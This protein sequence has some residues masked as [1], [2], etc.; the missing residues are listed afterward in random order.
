M[1]TRAGVWESW[2]DWIG[3]TGMWREPHGAQT[4]EELGVTR[5][6]IKAKRRGEGEFLD[7]EAHGKHP[8]ELEEGFTWG[9]VETARDDFHHVILYALQHVDEAFRAVGSVPQLAAV[10][11]DREANGV[12]DKTP[13]CH[14]EASNRVPEH[15]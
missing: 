6:P 13:V 10:G 11:E 7:V 14:G 4:L 2:D 5:Q 1:P 9:G 3:V 8:R 15:L 12:H